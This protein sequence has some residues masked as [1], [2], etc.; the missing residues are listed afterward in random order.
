MICEWAAKHMLHASC[1]VPRVSCKTYAACEVQNICCRWA[2]MICEWAANI[3]CMWAASHGLQM[4]ISQ[5]P[6]M[7]TMLYC[8]VSFEV[9]RKHAYAGIS[10]IFTIENIKFFSKLK[11]FL[12]WQNSWEGLGTETHFAR[13]WG[14][15]ARNFTRS[16]ILLTTYVGAKLKNSE[17]KIS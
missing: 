13:W 14:E 4:Y 5:W 1:Y 2:V 15:N 6:S 17:M 16:G 11:K 8:Y 7:G 9:L 12:T 3:C 10:S